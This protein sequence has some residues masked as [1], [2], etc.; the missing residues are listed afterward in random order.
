VLSCGALLT[1]LARTGPVTVMTVFT[2]ALPPARWALAARKDLRN[3][4]ISDAVS[5]FKDRRAEDIA[6]LK[7]A[8]ASWVHL[9]FTDALFRRVGET[10]GKDTGRAAYPTFRFDAS[11]GRIASSDADLAAK[12]GVMVRETAAASKAMAVFA[13]LGIGRHV[14]HVITRNAVATSGI[15]A[16]YYSDFPYSQYRKPNA[17]FIRNASLQPFTWLKGRAE[18]ANLMAGYK[19]QFE[20]LFPHGVPVSPETY[21][22]RAAGSAGAV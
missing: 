15:D 9:G 10:N 1:E 8:G 11:V 21:W 20:A 14:D 17:R 19:T 12:V 6:V 2:S 18:N 22:I 13:P 4:G 16:V 5:Y 3:L 7:E